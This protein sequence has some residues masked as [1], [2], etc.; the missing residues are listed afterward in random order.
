MF[1]TADIERLTNATPQNRGNDIPRA[2]GAIATQR[3][4]PKITFR[5][6]H[7]RP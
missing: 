7:V 6:V 3:P 2:L 5:I 4:K 1:L